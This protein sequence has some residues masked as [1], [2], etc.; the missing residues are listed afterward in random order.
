MLKPNQYGYSLLE[1]LCA[2]VAGS[3]VLL[4]GVQLLPLLQRQHQQM[5]QQLALTGQLDMLLWMMEKELHRDGFSRQCTAPPA[6]IVGQHRGEPAGSCFIV[7]YD[8]YHAGRD[9]GRWMSDSMG[10]RLHG[11]ALE[12]Q[13]GVSSCN[14]PG[15]VKWHEPGSLVIRQLQITGLAGGYRITLVASLRAAPGI[16]QRLSR[17]IS[18]RNP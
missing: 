14:Q 10:Y 8:F 11:G 6:L 7:H 18:R 12:S 15:W 17:I 2:M 1:T 16:Q 3:M 13:R 9:S 4:A 5:K